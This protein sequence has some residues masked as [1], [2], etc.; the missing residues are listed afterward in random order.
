MEETWVVEYSEKHARWGNY[1]WNVTTKAQSDRIG[2]GPGE[3]EWRVVFSGT[4]AE[5]F[6]YDMS[7][8]PEKES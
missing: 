4:S 8:P 6:A 2:P 5:C 1:P 3:G 7:K